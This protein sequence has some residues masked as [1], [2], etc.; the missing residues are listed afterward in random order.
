MTHYPAYIVFVIH[1]KLYEPR[2]TKDSDVN[3]VN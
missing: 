2:K 3:N 1:N